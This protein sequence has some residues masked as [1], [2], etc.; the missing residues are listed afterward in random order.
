M[1]RTL[2]WGVLIGCALIWSAP[3]MAAG[4]SLVG[5]SLPEAIALLEQTGLTV[6]YSTDL[7]RPH[8]RVA[9]EP[10][11]GPPDAQLAEILTPFRLNTRPGPGT[12]LLIVPSGRAAG[13]NPSLGSIVGLVRETPRGRLIDG[14][15]MV[16]EG[17]SNRRTTASGGRFSFDAIPP[18]TYL[19]TARH[20]VFRWESVSTV[21]VAAQRASVAM[22]ELGVPAVAR[23][24]NVIVGASQY[25]LLRA[26]GASQT[27]L[28]A[29]MLEDMPDIG[30]DPIRTLK[31]L[32][33]TSQGG[34]SA[35]TNVRG[36]EL[37]ETLVRVDNLRLFNPFHL[38]DFQSVFSAID[39][40][41]VSS[42]NVYTG[43]FP[44]MFGDRMSSVIDV[45]TLAP[46]A[47]RYHELS[48]SFFNTSILSAGLVNEGRGEW[49]ASLRR[50]NL[51]I[52]FDNLDSLPGKPSYLD[53]FAKFGYE[54]NDSLRVTGN[55]LHF[56][57]DIVLSDLDGEEQASANYEDNYLWLRLDHQLGNRFTGTTLV[58]HAKLD[59]DRRGTS[60]KPGVSS[61]FLDDQRSFSITSLQTDWQWNNG[62]R[63]ALSFGAELRRMRALYRYT[64][65]ADFDLLFDV[66]GA[67]MDLSRLRT[68]AV[69][70]EG[71]Q[72]GL[73]AGGRYLASD[74]LTLEAGLRWDRQTLDPGS[75]N[76]FSPRLG[77]R[78]ALNKNTF[79]RASLGRFIQSQAIN[80]LQVEDG[81]VQ[82]ARPQRSVHAV[83][84]LEHRFNSGLQLRLEGYTKRMEALRPRYENLLNTFVL[85]PEL[86][87]D[88]IRI[89]PNSARARGFEVL[90]RGSEARPIGWWLGYTWSAVDD[91]IDGV[92]VPRSW[93]QTHSLTA[94]LNWETSRWNVSLGLVHRSGWPTTNGTLDNNGSVPIVRSPAR[95]AARLDYYRS[96]DL[97]I[98]RNFVLPQSTLSVFVEVDN[99]TGRNN[100]CCIDFEFNAAESVLEVEPREYFPPI[101]SLGFVWQF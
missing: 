92:D 12:A 48:M 81:L 53:G 87:P 47:P 96:A 17:E 5:R 91:R 2:P 25:E 90:L 65:A 72:Y 46:P 62:D 10:A 14:V 101:P 22:L 18:G 57:D 24:D 50:S 84:G 75:E 85:L 13:L 80:E 94:G 19:L 98:A 20:P 1:V 54:I 8:M 4:K 26:V 39:P 56:T 52:W 100:P 66:S 15:E 89:A 11:P 31:R 42:I 60:D 76:Q 51:D 3:G 64:D 41:V 43:G 44:V 70:P 78:F 38:K 93:D 23:L 7:V 9:Q 49:L 6:L 95:N 58:A 79:L 33:G 67:S 77:V 40:R 27:L 73:Y 45:A 82:Y 32:P 83:V 71:E 30:D 55:L 34:V 88:R 29:A 36:G 59:S 35:K 97:R 86:Q 68:V 61:G 37:G 99:V 16:L 74:R 63:L 21:E 69:Q 28:T